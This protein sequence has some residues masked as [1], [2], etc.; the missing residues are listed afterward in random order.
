MAIGTATAIIGSAVLGAGA[1]LYGASRQ[2]SAA[3]DAS[4]AQTQANDQAIQL[5]REQ[6]DIA[7]R[8]LQPYAVR[9]NQAFDLMAPHLGMGGTRATQE[10]APSL[11]ASFTSGLGGA[12][13]SDL[14]GYLQANPDVM[15]H[16]QRL[17]PQ[18]RRQYPTPEAFAQYHYD[19]AG[20]A[21]GRTMPGQGGQ[22]PNQPA[23]P[24]MPQTGME[25][26]VTPE[27]AQEQAWEKYRNETTYGKI[28]DYEAG[29]ARGEF[30][31]M[32]ASG[33][34]A[35]SGRTMRGMAEVGEEA[36]MRN[37]Q[38]Y[39]GM[40]GGISDQGYGASTGIASSGQTFANNASQ[41]TQASGQARADGIRGSADAFTSGLADA[42]GWGG[43]AAGQFAQRPGTTTPPAARIG[44]GYTDMR[45][46]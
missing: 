45:D 41:L 15:Q 24:Q 44:S 12:G 31:D 4:R 39:M 11:A 3:R 34:S 7:S 22:Q 28:G 14:T 19:V 17:T 18:Q 10:R 13:G 33:G 35:L 1:S 25:E 30:M 43:W 8:T 2:S 37:F 42:A 27:Q 9:G 23:G 36:A 16:Y 40:L 21:E 32:A 26:Y 20:R 5:Q 38:G 6:R 46:Y 29:K